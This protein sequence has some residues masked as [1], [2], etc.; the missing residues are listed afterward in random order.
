MKRRSFTDRLFH[1]PVATRPASG[2]I[3]LGSRGDNQPEPPYSPKN[4]RAFFVVVAASSSMLT[5][6]SAAA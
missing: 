6:N 1:V 2:W 4:R 5:P 3:T